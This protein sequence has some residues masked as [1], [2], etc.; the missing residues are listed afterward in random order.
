MIAVDGPA[1]LAKLITQRERRQAVARRDIRNAG[2]PASPTSAASKRARPAPV[3]SS[4]A[5]TP[6][7][8][9]MHDVAVSLSFFVANRAAQR[10]W[11]G[12]RFEVSG[13]T[14]AG[15]GEVKILGRLA[16]PWGHVEAGEAHVLV[17]DDADL[18]LMAL[19]SRAPRLHV[20]NASLADA[21]KFKP[22]MRVMSVERLDARWAA[23]GL[24]VGDGGN[25]AAAAAAAA[26]AALVGAK[27]DLA[28]IAVLSSGNDYLPGV[29]G[30][31][32]DASGGGL[33]RRY[34]KLR[35]EPRWRH[36]SIVVAEDRPA[37]AVGAGARHGPRR[38]ATVAALDADF[39]VELLA[40]VGGGFGVNGGGGNGNG[41]GNGNGGGGKKRRGKKA[42]AGAADEAEDGDAMAAGGE[43][44][45]AEDEEE[46]D[47][48]EP[49]DLLDDDDNGASD[50]SDGAGSLEPEADRASDADA[51]DDSMDGVEAAAAAA[52]AASRAAAP[53]VAA[54]AGAGAKAGVRRAL[55]YVHGLLW[56]LSMYFAGGEASQRERAQPKR[57]G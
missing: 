3:V 50:G 39:L 51:D 40:G 15:E 53:S 28:L 7:T 12:V 17:G 2:L 33:W 21:G 29:R 52:A 45:A 32:M 55:D 22:S 26:P 4:T 47:A 6:G 34:V 57:G 16:R 30:A 37:G 27:A 44:E 1:P 25:G 14:V 11:A 24:A 19:M 35:K 49:E 18:I 48:R 13:P 42:A 43:D 56:N 9:F 41:N 10:R 20:L 8:E 23:M 5:L 31:S 46:D 38:L 36:R 54:A